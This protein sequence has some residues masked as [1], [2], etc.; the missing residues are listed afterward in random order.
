MVRIASLKIKSRVRDAHKG[1]YGHVFVLAG[2][3][4]LTG[5][6]YLTCMG[7]LVSGS[8]LVTLGVPKSINPVMEIKL[9]EVMTRPFAETPE[10]TLSIKALPE[11]ARFARKTDVT[12]IGPGLSRNKVTGELI[13]KTVLSMKK[14]F[15]LDADGLNAFEGRPGLLKKVTEAFVITPHP[16]EM[17]RLTGKSVNSI[18]KDRIGFAKKTAK[19][20]N[21]ITVLKGARTV[22]ANPRGELYINTTGNP[23]MAT[24]GVGDILTGMIASFIGQGIEPFG[25]AKLAAYLHGR[26]GDMASREKGEISMIATDLLSKLPEVLKRL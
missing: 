20:Y 2:S 5:A 26:A 1:D 6:A 16:G 19:H 3:P 12:A 14:P 7:S 24:G 15:V 13:V 21:C 18:Q 25:A 22:I 10:K 11:I 4:G 23:G 8:G 9:T 17:S